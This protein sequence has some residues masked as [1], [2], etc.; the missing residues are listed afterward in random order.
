MQTLKSGLLLIGFLYGLF[1]STLVTTPAFAA[2]ADTPL[3]LTQAVDP[4]VLF[5]ASRDHQLYVKAYTDY[6]D[7]DGDGVLDI[8]YTDNV[9]YYGYFDSEKCYS[10]TN[11]RFEPIGVAIGTN[12]HHCDAQW[13]GNFL[14]W[15]TMTRMDVIR[16]VLYGGYRLTP[17]TPSETILERVLLPYDVHAFSKVFKTLSTA[18]MQRYVPYAETTISLCSLTQGSGISRSV[19][20]ATAPPLLR[21]ARN[22]WPYWAASATPE[23]TWGGNATHPTTTERLSPAGSGTNAA[24]DG[25]IVRV[26]VCVNGMEENTCKTYPNGNKKPT[27]LLQKYGESNRPLRFGL[28]T[29]S[30]K[31]N[32]SG[33]VLRKNL[34]RLLGNAN[35]ALNEIDQD[36]GVFINQ[37]PTDVGIINTLNRFRI[38]SYD[39]T[40]LHY[41]NNCSNYVIPSFN[42]DQCIDW[43]NPL[44]ELY[45]E[46]LRYLSGKTAPTAAFDADDSGYIPS[47]PKV[48]WLDPTPADEFCANTS[49]VAIS[50]GLNSFD[51]DEV[52]SSDL[53]LAPSSPSSLTNDIG[54]KEGINGTT[55]FIGENGSNN[56]Q[57]CTAKSITGLSQAVGICPEVPHWKGGYH[58]AGLAYYAHTH[59]LRLEPDRSGNQTVD[60]YAISMAESLP[61][62]EIPVGNG[63]A[64][65]LPACQGNDNTDA[66]TGVWR[67]C[68][69]NDVTVESLTVNGGKM[70]AGSLVINWDASQ[71][72]ADFDMDASERLQFCVG[73]ACS[74]AVANNQINVTTSLFQ[75]AL[76]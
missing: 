64:T 13:S 49:I 46:A 19:N 62:F 31:K 59:D 72:G 38:A 43:G 24:N 41:Q 20:T 52:E 2:I 6:S 65:L 11:N 35:A 37:A 15:A 45:L 9:E 10:Y 7:L 3:F 40:S 51:N 73:N 55:V 67:S 4:R 8:T 30:Y 47:I 69:L 32:K 17:E 70:A 76:G 28:M 36:S 71:W 66:G 42:N 61:R 29:G 48:S 18:D 74:P 58:I 5:V 75:T 44:S 53:G 34:T 57:Q 56:D 25:L 1:V 21:V 27:G 50:T 23:C 14:N 54:Q 16:K 33:G 12:K 68:N 60:T 63:I 26:K 39:F 22:A